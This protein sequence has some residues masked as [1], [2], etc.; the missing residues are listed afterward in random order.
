MILTFLRYSVEAD[1]KAGWN[2]SK[3]HSTQKDS[4][5]WGHRVFQKWFTGIMFHILYQ[6]HTGG[7][8]KYYLINATLIVVCDVSF[9]SK[10][11][12]INLKHSWWMKD[13]FLLLKE[14]LEKIMEQQP[15]Q[16]IPKGCLLFLY[17]HI[18][19]FIDKGAIFAGCTKEELK[20]KENFIRPGHKWGCLE[21]V[22][23]CSPP[24][25]WLLSI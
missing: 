24:K 17:Q 22:K 13:P 7:K 8:K 18:M 6:N 4:K 10:I 9:S 21:E 5:L 11:I 3:R 20:N 2:C 1:T 15:A 14:G 23:F 19:S 25:R 16:V 12:Y